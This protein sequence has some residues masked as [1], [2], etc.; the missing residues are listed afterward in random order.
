MEVPSDKQ[1]MLTEIYDFNFV[2]VSLIPNPMWTIGI[3]MV[4]NYF[5]QYFVVHNS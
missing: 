5:F 4:V 3:A 2:F 1:A